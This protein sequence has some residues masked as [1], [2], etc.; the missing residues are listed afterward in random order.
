MENEENKVETPVEE[1]PVA[2][3]TDEMKPEEIIEESPVEVA[4]EEEII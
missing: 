2:P 3:I 1:A 4:P